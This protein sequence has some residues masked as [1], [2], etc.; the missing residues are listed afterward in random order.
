MFAFLT[1]VITKIKQQNENNNNKEIDEELFLEKKF[2][3]E[4]LRQKN[5]LEMESCEYRIKLNSEK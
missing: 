3:E 4:Y 1:S 2:A 5:L